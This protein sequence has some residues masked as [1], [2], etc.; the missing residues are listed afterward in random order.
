MTSNCTAMHNEDNTAPTKRLQK[1]L[2]LETKN[3][4]IEE[5]M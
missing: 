1:N 2:K 4:K 3:K 5:G